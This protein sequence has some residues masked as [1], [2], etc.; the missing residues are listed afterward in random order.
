MSF[1]DGA[2]ICSDTVPSETIGDRIVLNQQ[3][4]S[5]STRVPVTAGEAATLNYEAGS[6]L[7][8]M[9]QHWMKD[10]ENTTE[11]TWVVGNL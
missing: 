10:L 9:G 4:G 7:K 5:M 6:C 1:R 2:T 8:G 3:L 11:P